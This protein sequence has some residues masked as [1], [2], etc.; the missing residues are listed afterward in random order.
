MKAK[1][2]QKSTQ[3]EDPGFAQAVQQYQD[4]LRA[5]QERKFDRAKSLFQKVVAGPNKELADRA[6][7]HLNACNQ[8]LE[9]STTNF[10]SPEE[11]YDYAV[12]LI[13]VGDYVTAREHLEKLLKQAPHADY[14]YYG[15]AVLDC[16][17]GHFEN[18]LRNLAEAIRISPNNRFQARNDSDF[19]NLADDPRFTELLY[20]ENGEDSYPTG[21]GLR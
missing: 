7:V 14:V 16:L 18:S 2:Q 8:Y 21:S 9:R 20:P 1:A 6:S 10:R 11:H 4:G 12:S 15:L 17:T 3:T 19:N 13:N 5:L